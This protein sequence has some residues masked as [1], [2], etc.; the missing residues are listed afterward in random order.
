MSCCLDKAIDLPEEKIPFLSFFEN[1][2]M[3]GTTVFF[4]NEKAYCLPKYLSAP[5]K[6]RITDM[7]FFPAQ[8]NL[9]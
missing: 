4:L 5:P 7:A 2:I 8:K 1:I 6:N 3:V 9:Q